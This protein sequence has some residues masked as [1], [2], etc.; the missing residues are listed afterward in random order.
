MRRTRA[1]CPTGPTSRTDAPRTTRTLAPSRGSSTSSKLQGTTSNSSSSTSDRGELSPDVRAL[2][3]ERIVLKLAKQPGWNLLRARQA[4][5]AYLRFLELRVLYPTTS[6]VPTLDIDEM[7]H[8]HIL[9]TRAYVED[10]ERLFG[11]FMHHA[12][13]WD[14]E[15]RIELETAFAATQGL[16]MDVFG[17]ELVDPARCDGKP[18]HSPEPCRCR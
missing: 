15:N 2:D 7:W 6:L 16:W 8:A 3:L 13:A 5:L 17:E 11:S 4:E 9:D 10:C 12:P 1:S 14:G 18:C